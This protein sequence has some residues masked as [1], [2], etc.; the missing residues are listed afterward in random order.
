M[1]A[2]SFYHHG[3]MLDMGGGA[4]EPS[5]TMDPMPAKSH[6]KSATWWAAILAGCFRRFTRPLEE[7]GGRDPA[8]TAGG[9]AGGRFS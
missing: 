5:G 8:G 7:I 2:A 1:R 9:P 4:P 3:F 6:S